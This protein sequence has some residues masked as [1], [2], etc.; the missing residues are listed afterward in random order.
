MDA[1]RAR[2][3]VIGCAL[4][5]AAFQLTP[6]AFGDSSLAG[7][8]R[9]LSTRNAH[10][11]A[12]LAGFAREDRLAYAATIASRAA[13]GRRIVVAFV[14]V[15][16][17]RLDAYRE[18]LYGR[19]RLAKNDGALVLA[20]PR[21]ITMR[22]P[23]LTPDA[24]RAIIRLDARALDVPAPRPYTETLAEL[25]YDTGLVIHNTTPNAKPRG[26]GRERNLATFPG[27][28]AD[29][30]QPHRAPWLTRLALPLAAVV[31]AAGMLVAAAAVVIRRPR[32]GSS[33]GLSVSRLR[34]RRRR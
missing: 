32:P 5:P 3:A 34:E 1:T 12:A 14:D 21:S 24:E 8:A 20:T 10:V 26:S 13:D 23:N 25:V 7:T 6:A 19:L 31:L 11:D 2:V 15:P 29:E 33:A 9:A 17:A 4:L 18:Q 22:T 28:F 16:D 27:H 30:L